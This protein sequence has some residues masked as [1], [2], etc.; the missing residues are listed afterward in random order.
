M[1]E[2]PLYPAV[3]KFLRENKGC[4]RVLI[5]KV[6]FEAIGKPWTI[7]VVGAKA[8]YVYGVEVKANFDFYG[9]R[10]AL[11]QAEFMRTVCTHVYVCF[12]KEKYEMGGEEL[13]GYLS[14]RCKE[15]GVGVLVVDGE[16]VEEVLEP[17]IEK[18]KGV[19]DL[20]KYYQVLTQFTGKLEPEE[21]IR[22]MKALALFGIN[23]WLKKDVDRLKKY[24][25]EVGEVKAIQFLAFDFLWPLLT[26]IKFEPYRRAAEEALKLIKSEAKKRGVGP[27]EFL[28]EL[29]NVGE[30]LTQRV[31]DR[32]E[33]FIPII[34][35][36]ANLL[37][38]YG[39]NIVKLYEDKG[40]DGVYEALRQIPGLGHKSAALLM[41][42]FDKHFGLGLPSRLELVEEARKGL[43]KVALGVDEVGIEWT[44]LIDV[45]GWLL[46]G[47]FRRTETDEM[48]NEAF[49]EYRKKIAELGKLLAK[50]FA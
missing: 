42:E 46:R 30:F 48:L 36:F 20:D 19:I 15:L 47:G 31:G 32:A 9:V 39:G 1:S 23:R 35:G 10:D 18:I 7:D 25:R 14:S 8:P 33:Q 21:R 12:P 11:A 17:D 40:V 24:K 5:E 27:F 6:R 28:A 37:K 4:T 34:E 2:K 29:E 50:S 41:L 44:S 45:S 16:T 49:R 26:R 3:G 13:R 38:P 43:E 22:L